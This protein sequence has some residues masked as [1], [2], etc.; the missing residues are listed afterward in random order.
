MMQCATTHC[1]KR[2]SCRLGKVKR[3]QQEYIRIHKSNEKMK[4]KMTNKSVRY[5]IRQ[6]EK[7]RGTKTVAKKIHVTQRHIRRLR[8]KYL[9]T[10]VIHI[11]H[12]AGRPPDLMPSDEMIQTVLNTHKNKPE[13]HVRTANRLKKREG[14]NIRYYHAYSIVKSKSLVADSPAKSKQRK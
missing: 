14:P 9:K 13:G 8:T 3:I 7:G 10:K 12:P 2:K 4:P 11:Q 6:L 5:A 1:I